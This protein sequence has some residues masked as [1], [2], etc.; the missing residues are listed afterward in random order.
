MLFVL[1]KTVLSQISR[2]LSW[3]HTRH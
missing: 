3:N 2:K 1:T